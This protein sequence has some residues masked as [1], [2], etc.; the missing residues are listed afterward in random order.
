[1]AT[2]VLLIPVQESSFS[3][4]HGCLFQN[5]TDIVRN[6]CGVCK[7][8]HE[9]LLDQM[10]FMTKPKVNRKGVP[11][12][13]AVCLFQL[14][15]QVAYTANEGLNIWR[16]TSC[17]WHKGY[18]RCFSLCWVSS[19]QSTGVRDTSYGLIP[20]VARLRELGMNGVSTVTTLNSLDSPDLLDLPDSHWTHWTHQTHWTY[21]T[22]WTHTEL[23]G[24]PRI[25]DSPSTAQPV[26]FLLFFFIA[27]TGQDI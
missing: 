22:H 7:H 9:L 16:V 27:S 4:H 23:T 20:G 26:C 17:N 19:P 12:H 25:C 6:G 21:Q 2:T 11:W 10:R 1:M 3:V 15:L 18:A 14:P 8:S 13:R 5:K 24:S